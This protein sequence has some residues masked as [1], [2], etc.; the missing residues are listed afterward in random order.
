MTRQSNTYDSD[1]ALQAHLDRILTVFQGM[2]VKRV[3][4][5]ALAPNDNSKNQVYLAGNLNE[6]NWLPSHNL[7][8]SS[9]DSQKKVGSNIKYTKALNFVWVDCNGYRMDAPK[10]KVIYYPQYPEVRLSGF[11]QGSE[12]GM[13]GWMNP[14]KSGRS[15]NRFL[16]MGVNDAD[17]VFGYLAVPSSS[18]AKEILTYPQRKTDNAIYQLLINFN[19]TIVAT[20]TLDSRKLLLAELTRIH[21]KGFIDGKKLRHDLTSTP[22]MAPNGGGFTLEA[23]LGIVPN[24]NAL[25]DFHG[26]EIKQFGVQAWRPNYSKAITL[27]TPEPDAGEYANND[28]EFFLKKYG[29]AHPTKLDRWDF[30]GTHRYNREHSKTQLTLRIDGFDTFSKKITKADGRISFVAKNGVE[31]AS[32]TFPKLMEHWTTKHSKAAYIPSIKKAGANGNMS[33]HFGSKLKLF[34]GTNF[35]VFLAGFV[36]D[37]LYLDPAH[38]VEHMSTTRK[39]KKKRNQFRVKWRDLSKLYFTETDVAL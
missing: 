9:S 20:P 17:T 7:I 5:K 18:I 28:L 1:Q 39:P 10:T 19:S 21:R 3:F 30:N 33:Y 12:V 14:E 38:K 32:W 15:P 16:I 31:A 25:P 29:Y 27:L 34:E 36:E 11:L 8:A 6:V 26:W 35:E 22:Y 23:E 24:G 13:E 37:L 4:Y 2:G